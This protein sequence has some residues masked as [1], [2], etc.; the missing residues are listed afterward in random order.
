IGVSTLVPKPHTPF[1]WVPMEE[2]SVINAQ[3]DLLKRELRGPGIQFTWNDPNETL[4]EAFLTRGDRKLADVIERAWQLGAKLDAWGDQFRFDAWQQAFDECGLDMNWYARRERPLDE[5]LPWEHISAGLKK[6]FLMQEYV[7]TYQGGVV[8]D[9]REH[10]F[11]C[12]ILGYFK[13]QRRDA[14]DDGWA[15]PPL[16]RGKQRQPVDVSPIPLYF[17]DD[18]SPARTGQFAER[19]PQRRQ[20]TVAKR[21]EIGD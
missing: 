5:T 18:M 17:N 20:G 14:P 7:H 10:C 15:C 6:E 19:V 13:D 8:D 9:C 2:E 21:V 11:S 4:V 1:Q 12:G 3:I 16:G